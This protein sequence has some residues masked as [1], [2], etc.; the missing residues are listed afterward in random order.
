M[1]HVCHFP[2]TL[3]PLLLRVIS[4]FIVYFFPSTVMTVQ[5]MNEALDPDFGPS[6]GPTRHVLRTC[7]CPPRILLP[8]NKCKSRSHVRREI[9]AKFTPKQEIW[10]GK[11]ETGIFHISRLLQV[12]KMTE[13]IRRFHR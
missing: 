8:W 3:L 7:P 2:L 5:Q 4:N 11:R 10:P 12:N 6:I 13:K 9:E 1:Q